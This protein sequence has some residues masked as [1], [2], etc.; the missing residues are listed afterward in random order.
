MSSQAFE[1]SILERGEMDFSVGSSGQASRN[2]DLDMSKL[3][4]M[5]HIASARDAP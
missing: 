1:Q 5:A 2:V 4:D 3:E